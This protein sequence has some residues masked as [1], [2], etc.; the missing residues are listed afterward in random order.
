MTEANRR[1]FFR[2]AALASLQTGVRAAEVPSRPT[3]QSLASVAMP[4]RFGDLF[5]PPGLTNFLGCAQAALD[6]T[7]VRSVSFPP[8]AQGE[9]SPDGVNGRSDLT[10]VLFVDGEYQASGQDRISFVWRPDR[11]ERE[12]VTRGLRLSSLTIVPPGRNAVAVSLR[13]ENTGRE[14]RSLRVK[15]LLQGG[16]TRK[17]EPWGWLSPG[18]SDNKATVVPESGAVVF[19]S[20]HSQAASVQAAWPKP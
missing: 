15:L 3:C 18:E 11:I 2:L 14:R 7:A 20:L 16:V 9:I 12:C 19:E 8:F 1:D 17:A 13:I 5:N 4:H 6:M 10:G